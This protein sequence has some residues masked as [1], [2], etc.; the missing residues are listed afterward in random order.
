MP[1]AMINARLDVALKERV[2]PKFQQLGYS[3]TQV[4]TAVYQFVDQNDRLPFVIE[5]RVYRPEEALQNTLDGLLS[6]RPR[7]AEIARLLNGDGLTED[8]RK[9]YCQELAV[10]IGI[11]KND[12]RLYDAAGRAGEHLQHY[13]QY[14]LSEAYLALT[15]CHSIL[16]DDP[17]SYGQTLFM[18]KEKIFAG[19]LEKAETRMTEM[20]LYQVG[21]VIASYSHQGTYCTV[22]VYQPEGYMY[23]AW[24]VRVML[25]P[26]RKGQPV[27]GSLSWQ[28]FAFPKITDRIFNVASPYSV[29]VSGKHGL[30]IGFQF[31]EGYTFFHMYS[32]GTV[33]EKNTVSADVVASQLCEFVD[34][35]LTKIIAA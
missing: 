27:L 17:N 5:T 7:L 13:V 4:I 12:M 34:Q 31:V 22:E 6:A 35:E 32:N 16:E 10:D 9:K 19:A 20:G 30:E 8:A 1:L 23:G 15:L 11:I 33:E 29:P 2:D 24:Q 3:A 28:G 18:K 21:A 14:S 25:N 26:G